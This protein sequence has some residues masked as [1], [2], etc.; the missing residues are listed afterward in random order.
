M[1]NNRTNSLFEVLVND[2]PVGTVSAS[3][4]QAMRKAVSFDARVWLRLVLSV[5]S[6][7]LHEAAQLVFFVPLMAIW[8][9]VMSA[10]F[11][12]AGFTADLTEVLRDPAHGA[13]VLTSLL[14]WAV[15]L[16]V[17]ACILRFTWRVLTTD[18]RT[19][20]VFTA[21]VGRRLRQTVS[22]AAEGNIALRFVGADGEAHVTPLE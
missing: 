13:E 2:V 18:E 12:S 5:G 1:R 22:C 16:S 15:R 17:L 3:D 21:E 20:T 11:D 7:A 8:L 4:Y 14:S 19:A 6:R 9:L 10:V